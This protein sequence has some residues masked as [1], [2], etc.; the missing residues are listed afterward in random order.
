MEPVQGVHGPAVQSPFLDWAKAQKRDAAQ[1]P[2]A[3][4]SMSA[5]A[6]APPGP[7][8]APLW[9]VGDEW[10]YAYKSPSDSG[11][12][13][14]SVDRIESINGVPHYVIKTGQREIFYRVSGLATSLERVGGVVVQRQTPSRLSFTWP[15][16]V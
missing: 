14:W 10:Q 5:V 15:L 6:S 11:T 7:V 9:Q 8:M 4:G 13:V 12:Y 16:T 3:V 1:P 2:V